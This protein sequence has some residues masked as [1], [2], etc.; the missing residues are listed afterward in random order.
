MEGNVQKA[1]KNVTLKGQMA[2][3]QNVLKLLKVTGIQKKTS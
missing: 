2:Q 3:Y 1:S